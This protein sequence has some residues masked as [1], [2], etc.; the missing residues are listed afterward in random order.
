MDLRRGDWANCQA[1]ASRVPLRLGGG[2]RQDAAGCG[3]A[4]V[5]D[6]P[7]RDGVQVAVS[8]AGANVLNR[9]DG[10]GFAVGAAAVGDGLATGVYAGEEGGLCNGLGPRQQVVGLFGEQAAALFL[11]EEE[12]CAGR[13][14][15]ALGCGDGGGGVLASECGRRLAIFGGAGQLRVETAIGEDQEAEAV[16]QQKVAL[17]KPG[18]LRLAG[19]VGE[20]VS[21]EGE[22]LAQF[23]QRGV[24]GVDVAVEAEIGGGGG[25]VWNRRRLGERGGCD[26]GGEG[27]GCEEEG[28][29]GMLLYCEKNDRK[30]WSS[31]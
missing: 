12:D 6:D 24:A 23:G 13:K 4:G 8:D 27:D 21:G 5:L 19:R 15:L 7:E 26:D 11:V 9:G 31:L 2:G 16:A 14:A 3:W 29:Q 17:A 20:P 10:D 22:E 25:L 28:A 1:V 18:V 30:F